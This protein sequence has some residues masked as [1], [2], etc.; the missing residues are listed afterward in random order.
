MKTNERSLHHESNSYSTLGVVRSSNMFYGALP[1][2]F[3]LASKLRDRQT[4]AELYLWSQLDNLNCL[5][6]RFKRLHPI[7]YFVADFYC[8]KA[9]LIIEVDGGYHD[10]P[11]QYKYDKEREHELD[12]LGL[13]VIRFTNE[14]VLFQIENSLKAIEGVIKERITPGP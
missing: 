14:Q 13:K 6:V 4:E 3:E 11:E 1:I 2:L 9:K 7:L 8:H 5:N 12:D 10:L